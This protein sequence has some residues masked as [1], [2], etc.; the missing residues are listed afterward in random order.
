L[1][2]D[3]RWAV[4]DRLVLSGAA[5]YTDFKF[6]DYPNGQCYF[7]QAPTSDFNNDGIPDLCSYNGQS[8]QLV[9]KF[10]GT[11][12]ADYSYPILN[13]LALDASADISFKSKYDASPLFDPNGRQ[14]GYQLVNLRLALSPDSQKWQIAVLGKN[15]F[16]KRP[17]TYAGALPL[18]AG[19]FGSNALTGLFLQ[20]RQIAVQA[21]LNF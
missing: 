13:G 3:G 4:T 14:K 19:T 8:N 21:R 9:S 20:G 17:L 10:E 7:G 11:L 18:A 2:L 6:T 5:S 1:E 12:T 16:D 15:V